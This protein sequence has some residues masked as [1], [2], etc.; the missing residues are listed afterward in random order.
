M[1]VYLARNK[2]N[3][4][5]YVG[6]T[7]R[8]LEER[9]KEHIAAAKM[10]VGQLFGRAL[11]KHG[12]DAFEWQVLY[13]FDGSVN[14]ETSHDY[15]D[16]REREMIRLFETHGPKG[17]NLTDGGEGVRGLKH[18]DDTKRRMS[19]A[20]KGEKNVNWGGLSEEHKQNISI[21][22]VGTGTGPRPH[23]QG[24]KRSEEIREKI[25]K[26]SSE[27]AKIPVAVCQLDNEN[28][29]IATYRSMSAAAKTV[30][31][32][33]SRIKACCE[34]RQSTYRNSSWRYDEEQKGSR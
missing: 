22:K 33:G 4:K 23:V 20:R 34:L 3:G 14:E 1:I 8:S 21:A 29:V 9:R 10:G 2:V 11:R 25:S 24:R 28:R 12:F 6:K 26:A 27:R 30:N 16:D 15:L 31:G 5:G 19:E 18:S 13:E 32:W 7:T 17:Y